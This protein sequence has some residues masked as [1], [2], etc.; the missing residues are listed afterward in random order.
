MVSYFYFIGSQ[1]APWKWKG[2]ILASVVDV[3]WFGTPHTFFLN[4]PFQSSIILKKYF[5][6]QVLSIL[7]TQERVSGF[8]AASPPELQIIGCIAMTVIISLPIA[9]RRLD[10]NYRKCRFFF[11]EIFFHCKPFKIVIRKQRSRGDKRNLHITCWIPNN[12]DDI[13]LNSFLPFSMQL[14]HLCHINKLGVCWSKIETPSYFTG[15][16]RSFNRKWKGR[17]L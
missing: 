12:K 17:T 15:V 8:L 1:R 7:Y 11:Y 5:Y 16:T 6:I 13:A 14:S 3:I 4:I 9:H 10:K 2:R